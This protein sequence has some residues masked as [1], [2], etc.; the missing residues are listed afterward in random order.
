MCWTFVCK[1]CFGKMQN[2]CRVVSKRLVVL[3]LRQLSV[4][5]E[6]S[7]PAPL[8]MANVTYQTAAEQLQSTPSC[9]SSRGPS[10]CSSAR[11]EAPHMAQLAKLTSHRNGACLWRGH[12]QHIIVV[13][14][15]WGASYRCSAAFYKNDF[16]EKRYC[17]EMSNTQPT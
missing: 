4:V 16:L 9:A 8:S 6:S 10:A 12:V 3:G 7:H 17:T 11:L 2:W 13:R 5:L 1:S 15:S 14:T